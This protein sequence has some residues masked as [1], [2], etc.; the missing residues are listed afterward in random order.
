[1]Q[2]GGVVWVGVE[3]LVE[4]GDGFGDDVD[5]GDGEEESAWE[6]HGG[7]H[8]EWVAEAWEGGDA[9]AEYGDLEEEGDHE[10]DFDDLHALHLNQYTGYSRIVYTSNDYQ[11]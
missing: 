1:M 3:V 9:V 6:G 5:Q 11:N 8:D 4:L 7:V 2:W 10:A